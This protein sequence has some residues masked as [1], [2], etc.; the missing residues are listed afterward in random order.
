MFLIWGSSLIATVST[1]RIVLFTRQL[2]IEFSFLFYFG[3]NVGLGS[4]SRHMPVETAIE[5]GQIES[6]DQQRTSFE[7]RR[8]ESFQVRNTTTHCLCVSLHSFLFLFFFF[9]FLKIKKEFSPPFHF[10]T[11]SSTEFSLPFNRQLFSFYFFFKPKN[12]FY[13][14]FWS[15]NFSQ[16][17][18]W[19]HNISL[20]HFYSVW[21]TFPPLTFSNCEISSPVCWFRMAV[22]RRWIDDIFIFIFSFFWGVSNR[23]C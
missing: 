1:W 6:R 4:E 5:K 21:G 18:F 10:S 3:Q 19:C 13:Y 14:F 22:E 12:L 2:I 8:R 9:S 23:I 17:I 16:P 11:P 20:S 7:S 15:R